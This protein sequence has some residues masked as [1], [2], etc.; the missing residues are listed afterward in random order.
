MFCKYCGNQLSDDAKFCS[1]CGKI[2]D[3][4]ETVVNPTDYDFFSVEPITPQLD[5]MQGQAM[6]E[7][8]RKAG[9]ILKFA[10]LGLAL[11]CTFYLS[12][13]GVIFSMIARAKSRK[14]IRL[15]GETNGR[16][17]VGRHLS[18]AGVIAGWV[19]VGFLALVVIVALGSYGST[20]SLDGLI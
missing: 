8:D 12:L 3:A 10:I 6:Y 13:L 5:Y 18:L 4:N 19:I 14:Y 2:T 16:A 17:T 11:T 9:A 7:K 15:Y 1:K 20:P